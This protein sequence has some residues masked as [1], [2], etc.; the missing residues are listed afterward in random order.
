MKLTRLQ[1]HTA[2]IIMLA[3]IENPS[4]WDYRE[5]QRSSIENGLCW[6]YKMIFDNDFDY[7]FNDLLPELRK[8]FKED[9]WSRCYLKDKWDVRKSALQQCIIETA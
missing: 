9:W 5:E 1:R 4:M 8:Y 6:L 7:S 3:E 2:Y